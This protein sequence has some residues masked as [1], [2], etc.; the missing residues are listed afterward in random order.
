MSPNFNLMMP[1]LELALFACLQNR[2]CIT[3]TV[4]T[5]TRLL[6][7]SILLTFRGKIFIKKFMV[8]FWFQFCIAAHLP[9]ILGDK[10]H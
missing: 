5:P 9:A 8:F 6:I 3:Q 7:Y 1:R 10:Q 4:I 2:C